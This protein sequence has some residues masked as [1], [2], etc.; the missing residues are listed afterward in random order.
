MKTLERLKRLAAPTTRLAIALLAT[1]ATRTALAATKPLAVWNGDFGT[2]SRNGFTIDAK[3]NTIATDGSKITITS[4]GTGGILVSTT[5]NNYKSLICIAGFNTAT[6]DFSGSP[7]LMATQVAG[8]SSGGPDLTGIFLDS[9]TKKF[10]G[11]WA[12][13]NGQG[14]KNIEYPTGDGIHYFADVFGQ[15]TSYGTKAYLDGSTLVVEDASLAS[16]SGNTT[17]MSIGGAISSRKLVGAEINYIAVFASTNGEHPA[18][19][20]DYV[21]IFSPTAMTSALTPASGAILSSANNTTLEH[22]GIN[23]PTEGYITINGDVTVAALFAQG[24]SEI[25]FADSSSSLTVNG[26]VY[27]AGSNTLT[28]NATT[29]N[30]LPGESEHSV[31]HDA[32]LCSNMAGTIAV[33]TPTVEDGYI[34]EKVE[35][36]TGYHI[37][38]VKGVS[39]DK[40]ITGSK[41]WSSEK[42][43]D[44]IDG[45]APTIDITV[46]NGNT[47][48]FT[49]DE[50]VQ[51][52]IATVHCDGNL[53]LTMGANVTF[54]SLV[55][56]GSGNVTLAK[57]GSPTIL[58]GAYDFS[59]C[60]G[61]VT[62]DY[63]VTP[64]I[65]TGDVTLGTGYGS[66][67][68]FPT[69][70]GNV[71]VGTSMSVGAYENHAENVT[72]STGKSLTSSGQISLYKTNGSS[73]NYV[74]DGGELSATAWYM[75]G[76]NFNTSLE[77][78]N[79][80][81]AT[82]TGT[83]TINWY[84]TSIIPTYNVRD[85]GSKLSFGSIT[86]R[87]WNSNNRQS[88]N[89]YDGGRIDFG[90]SITVYNTVPSD[91]T[92]GYDINLTDS[93]I[94]ATGAW[95]T[96]KN[97]LIHDSS[98]SIN[99]SGA[100]TFDTST[101]NVTY[102]H[103]I[104]D[105]NA[106]TPGSITKTGS[107]KLTLSA[108]SPAKGTFTVSAGELAFT[109]GSWAGSVDVTAGT[110]TVPGTSAV[111]AG[112]V[113][114]RSG[115]ILSIT[116]ES[117]FMNVC[118]GTLTLEGG[119]VVKVN[120]TTVAN[121][122]V[123][124][125]AIVNSTSSVWGTGSSGE[126]DTDANWVTGAAP[127]AQ[128]AVVLRTA[129]A[130]ITVSANSAAGSVYVDE[131]T[132]IAGTAAALASFATKVASITVASGK[133]LT[134]SCTDDGTY[135]FSKAIDGAGSFAVSG[136]TV[137]LSG[138]ST[139][140]GNMI[141][142]A[143][144]K[145]KAG[146]SG[147]AGDGGSGPFG[148]KVTATSVAS[149]TRR[150]EVQS[151]G[152]IDM[153]GNS[154]MRYFFKL[155]G[156]GID[157]NGA[158]INTGSEVGTSKA[159][160]SGIELAGDASIGG[161]GNF[162]IIAGG[163]E[164]T[165]FDL[166]G[167]TLS[168]KG[169]NTVWVINGTK[170][171]NSTTGTLKVE[172]GVFNVFDGAPSYDKTTDL[173][174][175]A[176]QVAGGTLTVN[177]A[178][179]IGALTQSGGT[180][181]VNDGKTLTVSSINVAASA[182]MS[183]SGTIA[184]NGDMT[185]G[186]TVTVPAGKTW[187]VSETLTVKT[188]AEVT[189]NGTL[190]LPKNAKSDFIIA[191][192]EEDGTIYIGNN[193]F[194][195]AGGVDGY[196]R[197]N[198]YGDLVVDGG[199]FESIGDMEI[200]SSGT[201]TV[202]GIGSLFL[203]NK[204]VWNRPGNSGI[205]TLAKAANLISRVYTSGATVTYKPTIVKNTA[206]GKVVFKPTDADIGTDSI[207]EFTDYVNIGD[208]SVE[209]DVTSSSLTLP[210]GTSS[211]TLFSTTTDLS[212]SIANSKI[213][214]AGNN[215]YYL[216][217]VDGAVTLQLHAAKDT[218]GNYYD[219]LGAIFQALSANRVLTILDGQGAT[220]A[221]TFS[222]DYDDTSKEL[223]HAVA[224]IGETKY[225]SLSAAF[226]A[227]TDGQTVTL[228]KVSSE[229]GVALNDKSITF[230]ENGN[231]FGG[232]LT[233]NGTIKMTAKPKA[234]TSTT[235]N[236]GSLFGE[237]WTGI[238]QVAWKPGNTR[239]V[240]D[241]FG[242]ANST[243]EIVGVN[244]AFDAF[245]FS[246]WNDGVAPNVQPKVSIAFGTTWT[247]SDGNTTL[248]HITTFSS[249]EGGGNLIVNGGTGSTDRNLYY[250]LTR[251][252]NYTG[253]L[254]GSRCNYKIVN[255]VTSE[256]DFGDCLVKVG[257]NFGPYE[258]DQTTVNGVAANLCVDTLNSQKGI[259]KTAATVT[260][261]ATTTKYASV[262]NA[263]AA[264]Q[265]GTVTI[266]AD[267]D[268]VTVNPGQSV[269]VADGVTVGTISWGDEYATETNVTGDGTTSYT[270]GGN[271][272]TTYYWTG[273]TD[274]AWSTVGNWA[275]GAADGPTATR[276]VTSE[277]TVVFPSGTHTVALST[278]N[279]TEKC[280]AMTITGDVTFQ[281]ANAGTWAYLQINGDVSGTG[282][283]TL[284]HVGLG[285]SS[286]RSISCPVVADG[287]GGKDALCHSSGKTFTFTNTVTIDGEFKGNESPLTFTGPVILNN[288]GYVYACGSSY[289]VDVLFNGGITVTEN[290]SGSLTRTSAGYHTI[291]S[292]V[293]LSGG[294]TLTIPVNTTVSAA[295]FAGSGTVSFAATPSAALRFGEWTGTVV[296]P[297]FTSTPA[298]GINLN[299][300]GKTGSTVAFGGMSSGCWLTLPSGSSP[301]VVNPNLR[302]TGDVLM[303]AM[304]GRVY[305]FQTISGTGSL[306]VSS[307]ALTSMTIAKIASDYTGTISNTSGKPMTISVV[308]LVSAPSAG[309]KILS[310]T[311]PNA[312]DVTSVY[313]GTV[314]QSV[315]LEKKSDGIYVA[316]TGNT[317]SVSGVGDVTVLTPAEGKASLDASNISGK[318]AIPGTVT[319]I[320]GV[321]AE[322]L[323]L[324]VTY[325][326]GVDTAYYPILSLDSSGNV[327]LNGS[328]T[329]NG[330]KV[331]P[332]PVDTAPIG[333]AA[334]S[335]P[336]LGV[337]AIPGLWY[338][339][340]SSNT[341]NGTFTAEANDGAVKQANGSSVSL[342]GG[343][344][345]TVKYYKI[346]VGTTQADAQQ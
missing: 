226:A 80:G 159:N 185:I 303:S 127:S 153:N 77:V 55:I 48:D 78:K 94:G 336:T 73:Q 295:T 287:T 40:T 97:K 56:E 169:N 81:T 252:A 313:V 92:Y 145:A 288:G 122:L 142:C 328:A 101:Y 96:D 114:V 140:T 317:E 119:A 46:E 125:G 129:N 5:V 105:Q 148:P 11:S 170:K 126:W 327:S 195:D 104:A 210:T 217:Q 188:D 108:A 196:S 230:A 171:A 202:N 323:L 82:F 35:D 194:L 261:D 286:N 136:G 61:A 318:I 173:S 128:N 89:V 298:D 20:A 339:L 312:V 213:S 283:L 60:T 306:S 86:A 79:G 106:G 71:T 276:A 143:S 225:P 275:V 241:D 34:A 183:P 246:Q 162:G 179:N 320:N 9:T 163:Y 100:N 221:E 324:K 68:A 209:I 289:R 299:N 279:G 203:H 7:F 206:T 344:V 234:Y 112:N 99:L 141:V 278:N 120:G 180:V 326:S 300:Y 47:A 337:K 345:T 42:P 322:N 335:A 72:I 273:T 245:P 292:Q 36:D 14:G 24:N 319:Q 182:T 321:T 110:L 52:G 90:S 144:T 13:G 291:A 237:G 131:S 160:V 154:E 197:F 15:S 134:L 343:A 121:S 280:G 341:P 156:N 251:V 271:V 25:C 57:S 27:V 2:A 282:T 109:T 233:G 3:S 239:F 66:E 265:S 31:T 133:T 51:A 18:D 167:H 146:A 12:K 103:Q 132:T 242:N 186:G 111:I 331:Q 93:T 157:G 269:V 311:T 193:G 216:K 222:A 243:V 285:T 117:P 58:I 232:T 45:S 118:S 38:V 238:F 63:V 267:T 123:V 124:G 149:S 1:L 166:A 102:N 147:T 59:A 17:G 207:G 253:A 294:S 316:A 257:V 65:V 137:T 83:S 214:V 152:T 10:Q 272:A 178:F 116:T 235:T 268:T 277:D 301:V 115:A 69:F 201:V 290:S 332:E 139:F 346:S 249:L 305:S 262:A 190:K 236:N 199:K 135:T 296:L 168:K 191:T 43:N 107:G 334:A 270:H 307:T 330:V 254:S 215:D 220:Y 67:T 70:T 293:T 302:L 274:S 138:A 53:T 91:K 219:D 244:G 240:L 158:L 211:I 155:A 74:V 164:T 260:V 325:N 84:I 98:V 95:S 218:E 192:V 32:L 309:D 150:V 85:S 33:T 263:I 308:D 174:D 87:M 37:R 16:S 19:V 54:S 284:L 28:V 205:V 223:F 256:D 113:T 304:S 189:I 340:K 258:L 177:G 250:T 314:Q 62:L 198:M 49:F 172:A 41:S 22:Q 297:T 247:V 29:L 338:A 212:T 39:Y 23:L 4:Q 329:V 208:G 200:F 315:C 184:C 204:I 50:V 342:T 264:G 21:R 227:A 26:V 281:R 161:S 259:Y 228:L 224:Q 333:V 231:T 175:T 151:G 30:G 181:N 310:T 44:W 130:T 76:D 229:A 266:L 248:N 165:V 187:T 176:V 64:S 255:I 75:S 6:S 8:R 88:I